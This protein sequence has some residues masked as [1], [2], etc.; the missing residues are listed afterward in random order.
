[1]RYTFSFRKREIS[2]EIH[3]YEDENE[4]K[5]LCSRCSK[6]KRLRSFFRLEKANFDDGGDIEPKSKFGE[7]LKRYLERRTQVR[8]CICPDCIDMLL[9]ALQ[10]E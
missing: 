8:K 9:D 3:V 1:M 2:A 5:K 4:Q 10:H 6:K 7:V